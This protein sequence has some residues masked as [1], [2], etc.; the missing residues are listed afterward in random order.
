VCGDSH[1]GIYIHDNGAGPVTVQGNVTAYNE[2]NV[3]MQNASNVSVIGNYIFNPRGSASCAN[4]DNLYGRQVQAWAFPDTSRH[5]NISYTNNYVYN[6]TDTSKF[7]FAG[8]SADF[9]SFG[10]TNGATASNNWVGGTNLGIY[11]SATGII[12]DYKTNNA[13]FANNIVTDV[14]QS[15]I[16][17]AG[18]TNDL[19]SGNKV[20]IGS[21]GTTGDANS[22]GIGVT[23]SFNSP[24][25]CNTITV[26]NNVAYAK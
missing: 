14:Y 20:L 11:S 21:N 25:P 16:D 9:L 15:G 19:I 6:S 8:A 10:V 13:T 1:D 23:G 12:A 26:S 24:L 7:L 3:R 2:N 4:P 18:G 22:N 17:V 5:S